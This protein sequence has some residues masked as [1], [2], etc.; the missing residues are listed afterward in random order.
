M[1]TERCPPPDWDEPSEAAAQP[2][3]A[4]SLARY[5]DDLAILAS[6]ADREALREEADRLW[7]LC[8]DLDRA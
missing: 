7:Q 6:L 4:I 5:V 3:P 8:R 2:A 1:I